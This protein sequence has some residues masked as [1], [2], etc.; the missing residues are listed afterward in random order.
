MQSQDKIAPELSTLLSSVRNRVRRFV[1]V[2]SLLA[3]TGLVTGVFWL[4]FLIDQT[5]VR[6][7]GTEMPRLARILFF[8]TGIGCLA[9][10]TGKLLI[11]RLLRPL[12]DASLALLI[13][14]LYPELGGRLTTAVEL[15]GSERKID[16]HSQSLLAKVH[17]QAATLVAK[18]EP[19]RLFRRETLIRKGFLAGPLSVATVAFLVFDPSSF[20][21]AAKRL[22]LLS[23]A[24]WPRRADIEMV[25]IELP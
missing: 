5:P 6:F 21:L 17:Q 1:L 19:S 12:P 11:G 2:D 23:D 25:G 8:S 4:G 24:P 7:G 10:L 18:V 20:A 14:R 13:E 3:I 9:W 16:D 15:L 22:T